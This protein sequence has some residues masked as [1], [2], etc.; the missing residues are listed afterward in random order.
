MSDPAPVPASTSLVE[1]ATSPVGMGVQF[2]YEYC[3]SH[4]Y[5]TSEEA[6]REFMTLDWPA[7]R[8]WRDLWGAVFT[9]C[10]RAGYIKKA[11][12][13]IPTSRVS[14]AVTTSLWMSQIYSGPRTITD[15]GLETVKALRKQWVLKK[16]TSME[17]LLLR[18][19]EVGFENG[20]AA[21]IARNAKKK[22]AKDAAP[23]KTPKLKI[24]ANKETQG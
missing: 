3:K 21:I 18:A 16:V 24:K 9:N 1:S 5:F 11:G 6:L 14:H 20:A 12:R 4:E 8:P 15:S 7:E 23:G 19:Y 22:E 10:V 2:M 13:A 17:Q